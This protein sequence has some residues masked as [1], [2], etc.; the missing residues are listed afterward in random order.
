VQVRVIQGEQVLVAS[1]Q[2]GQTFGPNC[3]EVN[4]CQQEKWKKPLDLYE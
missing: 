1:V 4:S 3:G 2:R